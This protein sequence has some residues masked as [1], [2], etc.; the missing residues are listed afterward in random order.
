[1]GIFNFFK[2]ITKNKKTEEPKTEKLAFSEIRVWIEKKRNENK[3]KEKEVLDLIKDKTEVF[4]SEIKEKIKILGGV[5]IESKKAEEKFKIIVAES[6]K[7]YL[8]FIEE[9]TETLK[10]MKIDNLEECV[11]NIK[12]LFTSYTKRL[13]VGYE[14]T[15]ILIGKEI[16]DVKDSLKYFSKDLIKIFDENKEI[17]ECFK[18]LSLLEFKLNQ[19]S[20]ADENLKKITEEI[21][22]LNKK[23]I[24]KEQEHKEL[25]EKIEQIRESTVHI[26]Y[27][28]KQETIE[29]LENNLKKDFLNLK[30][31]FDFKTL[32]NIFHSN[33]EK[34]NVLNKYKENFQINFQKDNGVS[35]LNLLDEAKLNKETIL[36]KI[37]SIKLKIEEINKIKQETKNDATKEISSKLTKIILEANDLETE[38]AR[39]EKRYEK[40]KLNK[41]SLINSLSQE[42]KKMNIELNQN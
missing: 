10:N 26:E 36:E 23:I 33:N 1:M 25:T 3:I 20:L 17:I 5:D 13:H 4:I 2:K 11:H 28:K 18:T 22:S 21:T 35:I 14:K 40:V 16:A 39:E 12:K 9:F 15:T 42:F 7:K 8:E 31:L 37:N 27:L 19:I 30:Q 38:K 34:M 32:A 41:E 24:N 6:R 29:A